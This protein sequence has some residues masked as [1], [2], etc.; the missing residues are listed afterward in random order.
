MGGSGPS[1]V[2]SKMKDLCA[3]LYSL[4]NQGSSYGIERMELLLDKIGRKML[5]IPVIHVAGTNGK[6]STCAMLDAIYRENGY[7][8]GLFSSPHLVDLGERIRVNGKIL[9]RDK[10]LDHI[11]VLKPYAEEIEEEFRGMHPS[12]FEMMTAVAFCEFA[13]EKV[14]LVVLETGLG[15]RLDSTNVVDPVVSV[16]TT[17]SLDHCHILGNTVEK[18]AFE[19]AGIVKAGRPV[20]T[21][22]LSF[23]ANEVVRKVALEKNSS[24]FTLADQPVDQNLPQT[25]LTGD[26]QK[27]NAALA[28]CVTECLQDQ[29]PVSQEKTKRGLHHVS[30]EGRW[31]VLKNEPQIVLDACHNQEGALAL[32]EQ[33]VKL[34][35]KTELIIWFGSL[36]E[37]RAAEIL[38]LISEF[39]TQIRFFQPTQPR[40]CSFEKLQ[41][42]L[43]PKY[44]GKVLNGKIKE[45]KAYLDQINSNQIL[46]I[47]GSIYLLGEVL[48]IVKN[49]KKTLSADFQDLI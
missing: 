27:R 48:E 38:H 18:I 39:A 31:Q 13:G 29:F 28:M 23:S 37:E 42:L 4:R 36:G 3:Y 46:L 24:F 40:S 17:I 1:L 14:D 19:K 30:L 20:I 6:G 33:L 35:G 15:G 12:F 43:P 45:V 25:N 32:R 7:K 41:S 47:T 8:V 2:D 9:S 5:N 11:H 21:G 10:L 22:W 16:I 26:H 34:S 49:K 44:S